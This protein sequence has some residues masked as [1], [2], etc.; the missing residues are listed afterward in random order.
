MLKSLLL[1][2]VICIALFSRGQ[3]L[4]SSDKTPKDPYKKRGFIGVN[5]GLSVPTGKFSNDT[6]DDIDNGFAQNGFHINYLDF[7]YKV[8][9]SLAIKAAYFN[10]ANEID[11]AQLRRS[12]SRFSGRN[13]I[14]ASGSNYEVNG[15]LIGVSAIK[16]HKDFDLGI[17]FLMGLSNIHI[18]FIELGYRD[19]VT[20]AEIKER[21]KPV[22][23]FSTGFSVGVDLRIHLNEHLDF[24]SSLKYVIFVQSFTQEITSQNVS[25]EVDF[26]LTYEFLA[27]T[28]GLAYR[29]GN[30]K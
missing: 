16:S 3:A 26:D 4:N 10:N 23:K 6:E 29:F 18:P 11:F 5:L 27:P 7:G 25:N 8:T 22:S 28:I 13:Y 14:S 21:F 1:S 24:T 19:S 15:L 12:R 20:N 9:K 30:E 2:V 17:N